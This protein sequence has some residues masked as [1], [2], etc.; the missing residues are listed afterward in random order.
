[1]IATYLV[2][3][4]IAMFR[5]RAAL[6]QLA[7]EQAGPHLEW[8]GVTTLWEPEHVQRLD[9]ELALDEVDIHAKA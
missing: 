1:M 6:K 7:E 3:Y 9:R 2:T 4:G 8:I 5:S